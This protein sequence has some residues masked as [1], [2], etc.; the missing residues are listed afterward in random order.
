MVTKL[1]DPNDT[2]DGFPNLL[3]GDRYHPSNPRDL[4]HS[5]SRSEMALINRLAFFGLW[6]R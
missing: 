5:F 4:G 6:S 3:A 1:R 2:V